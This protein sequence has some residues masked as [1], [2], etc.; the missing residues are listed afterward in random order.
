MGYSRQSRP[1]YIFRQKLEGSLCFVKQASC[2]LVT[3]GGGQD[4]HSQK[5]LCL[6]KQ[7]PCLLLKLIQDVSKIKLIQLLPQP[8]DRPFNISNLIN[9]GNLRPLHHHHGNAQ[10]PS[11]DNFRISSRSPAIF[12]NNCINLIF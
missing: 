12:T 11:R 5:K 6:V 1:I 8:S 10:F 9:I 7:A 2:L 3:F 4:A